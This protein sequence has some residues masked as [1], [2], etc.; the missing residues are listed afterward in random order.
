VVWR[1]GLLLVLHYICDVLPV[2]AGY[3]AGHKKI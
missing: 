2:K 1:Y 3:L